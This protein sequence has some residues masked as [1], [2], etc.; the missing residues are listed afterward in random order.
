M[1]VA[2]FLNNNQGAVIA[3]LTFVYVVATLIIVY[4]NKRSIDEMRITREEEMRPYIFAYLAFVPREG[5]C[6]T[7]VVKNYGKSGA[8]IMSFSIE[9][10]VKLISGK[11]DCAF[12]E[13]TILAPGQAIRLLIFDP[14]AEFDKEEF[15]VHITYQSI[16][17]TK[18]FS[19]DYILIQQYVSQSGYVDTNRSGCDKGE[20]ALINIANSLDTMKTSML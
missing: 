6:L 14:N 4:F 18:I 19:E 15:T 3:S 17:K 13:G 11:S 9:P 5:K 10:E 7:L 16:N 12:M 20:N 2:E 8:R 1:N